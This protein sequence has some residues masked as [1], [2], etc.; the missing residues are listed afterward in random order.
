MAALPRRRH[1][2]L[3]LGWPRA[4]AVAHSPAPLCRCPDDPRLTRTV[5]GIDTTLNQLALVGSRFGASGAESE[6]WG[7]LLEAAKSGVS[8]IAIL[9]VMDEA[10]LITPDIEAGISPILR[11]RLIQV[12][13]HE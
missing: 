4:A 5:S 13:A 12:R 7:P 3:P 11:E 2:G 9:G 10:G 1:L 8:G 6:A